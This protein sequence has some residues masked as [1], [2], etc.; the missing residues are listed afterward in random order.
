MYNIKLNSLAE[1]RKTYPNDYEYAR[2]KKMLPFIC[3]KM[4][5]EIKNNDSL[6]I[7]NNLEEN[8]SALYKI[9]LEVEM[10]YNEFKTKKN[11]TKSL[12]LRKKIKTLKKTLILMKQKIS[13]I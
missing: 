3:D 2:N 11:K 12:K 1:W 13:S 6:N 8:L 10:D 9:F 7:F 4:G 5:W